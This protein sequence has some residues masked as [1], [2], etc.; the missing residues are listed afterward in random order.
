MAEPH[1]GCKVLSTAQE[2][3]RVQG[4]AG[5]S[6][7]CFTTSQ[8]LQGSLCLQQHLGIVEPGKGRADFSQGTQTSM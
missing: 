1:R 2:H 3:P 6:T 4:R 7:Q 8:S 5:T